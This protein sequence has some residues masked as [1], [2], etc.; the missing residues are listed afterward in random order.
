MACLKSHAADV[1]VGC[2]T[3]MKDAHARRGQQA[4]GSEP[5]ASTPPGN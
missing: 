4:A 3:A 2:K 1:S 5:P